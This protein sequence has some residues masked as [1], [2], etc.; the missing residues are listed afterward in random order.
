VRVWNLRTGSVVHELE[1]GTSR[2][3]VEASRFDTRGQVMVRASTDGTVRLW[4]AEDG[5]ARETFG[6]PGGPALTD[7]ALSPDGALVLAGGADPAAWLWRRRDGA[8]VARLR[9]QA[10]AVN[11]VAYSPDGR[12]VALAAGRT[13]RVWR[14][15]AFARPVAVFRDPGPL[16]QN[17]FWSVAFGPDGRVAA[18]DLSGWWFVWDVDER[19]LVE[20]GKAARETVGDLAFS[21]DGTYLVTADWRGGAR[22]WRFPG[23]SLVTATRTRSPRLDAA[24]FA[25]RGRLIAIGGEDGRITVFECAECRPLRELVCLA[26]QRVTPAVRAE[27]R[28]AFAACD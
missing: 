17:E 5:E 28:D 7:A 22:V 10:R 1:H 11:A 3:W 26:E 20:R 19:A 18:G 6:R 14:T 15:G 13:V 24:A 16:E 27:E 23:G 8:L 21:V 2:D 4:G 12:F 9:T 25:P